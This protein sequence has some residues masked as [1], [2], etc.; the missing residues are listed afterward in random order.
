MFMIIESD[1][2][3]DFIAKL[4][5]DYYDLWLKKAMNIVHDEYTAKDMVNDAFIKLFDK[6][7]ILY[8]MECY[9]RTAYIV[10]TI[11][12]T[13]KT[14]LSKSKRATQYADSFEDAAEKV[15]DNMTPEEIF[16]NNYDRNLISG[17]MAGLSSE[18]KIIL[19]KTYYENLNDREIS[20]HTGMKYDNIRTF[21]SRLIKKIQK[22][23]AKESEAVKS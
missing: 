19:E 11:E 7:N 13:C 21:R 14:Y 23:Y 6:I 1:N 12:N 5:G 2:E 15:T 9:K 17:I 20:K 22:L 18:E 8:K 10:I 4:Y 3:R 16:I